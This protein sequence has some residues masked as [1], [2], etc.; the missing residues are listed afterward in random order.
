[1]LSVEAKLLRIPFLHNFRRGLATNSSSSHSL[2]YVSREIPEN[3]TPPSKEEI[4]N[5]ALSTIPE[6]G[7]GFDTLTTLGAKLLYALTDRI[8]HHWYSDGP[9]TQQLDEYIEKYGH[10][11]PEFEGHREVW[12]HA[13]RGYV[14]HESV[15]TGHDLETI[16]DPRVVVIVDNDN[17]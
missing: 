5:D 9:S 4:V 8:G 1:M 6:F 17:H 11:F 14:D 13:A 2:V 16:R 7:W 12:L 3:Y 15:G 10:L